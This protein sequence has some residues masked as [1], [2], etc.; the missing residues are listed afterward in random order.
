VKVLIVGHLGN[1][2]GR[3]RAIL[4][5]LGIKWSG[6][7]K[8]GDVPFDVAAKDCDR[9]I[10]A[11]PTESHV[12]DIRKVAARID[13]PILCEKPITKSISEL[14]TLLAW[15]TLT[16]VDLTMVYQYSKLV[17]SNAHGETTYDYW[18]HGKDGLVWDC[19]QIIGLAK[20]A[21]ELKETSPLWTCVINGHP[22]RSGGMDNAYIQYIQDWLVDSRKCCGPS[23]ILRIHEKTARLNAKG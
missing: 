7:D 19:I 12:A 20:G 6:Y 10:I 4:N 2:G 1:M 13:G 3:Y 5:H 21:L 18:Y 16:G 9:A 14:E 17:P 15:V 22:L 23:E 11:T 8:S